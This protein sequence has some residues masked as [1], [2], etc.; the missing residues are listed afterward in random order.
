MK[1]FCLLFLF[2]C[3][4]MQDFQSSA[5]QNNKESADDLSSSGC[6]SECQ[7]DC[8]EIFPSLAASDRCTRLSDQKVRLIERAV[9]SMHRGLWQSIT[10]EQ[11]SYIVSVSNSPWL[12][13]ADGSTE[14]AENMLIWL[15]EN[16][17]IPHYLD[18]EGEILKTVLASL[19]S[20][21][22][23]KGVKDSFSK[24]V[25]DGR[26]FLEMM[27]WEKNN[28]G[29]ERTHNIILEVCEENEICIRQTYCQ[30]NSKIVPDTVNKLKLNLDFQ[31]FNFACP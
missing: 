13:Y 27:A 31:D 9:R 25:K 22:F 15:A 18:D 28:E 17:K 3:D 29:F 2:G 8:R 14:S 11:I 19:S 4:W 1:Y 30:N 16:E 6:S 24:E 5:F 7:Q 21:S 12:R 20:M 10:E 26:T 23:D